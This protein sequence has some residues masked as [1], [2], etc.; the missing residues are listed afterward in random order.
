VP[1]SALR[2]L[3]RMR[4]VLAGAT[5]VLAAGILLYAVSGRSPSRHRDGTYRS[6]LQELVAAAGQRRTFEPRVTGNFAYGTLVA[7][8]PT[9]SAASSPDD[10]PLVLRAAAI[11][12]EK[13]ARAS[14][15]PLALNAFGIA[16][17]V[18]GQTA[19]A[20]ATL[21][22]AIRLA[23]KDARLSSDLAAGYLVRGRESSR[24]ED[25]ARAVGLA[26]QATELD[27]RLA[28]ARF[29]LALSLE[30]L[31]LRS[32]ASRAWQSYLAV[33]STSEWAAEA[34]RHLEQLSETPE[35]RWEKQRREIIAA[36]DRGDEASIRAA[37]GRFPDTAYE[38][39]ENDLIPAWADAWLARDV[40][41]AA[42]SLKLA[43]L[44]GQALADGVGDRMALDA[45]V[46]IERA[47]VNQDRADRLARAHQLFRDGR[48]VYEQDRVAES[49]GRFAQARPALLDCRSPFAQ[50]TALQEGIGR[51]YRG[52][53]EQANRLLDALIDDPSTKT[54]IR[55]RGRA[56][57]M[58]GLIQMVTGHVANSL[59]SYKEALGLFDSAGAIGDQA[60]MHSSIAEALEAIG[61]LGTAWAHKREALARLDV[62]RMPRRRETI[63]ASSA[64]MARRGN[65]LEAAVAFQ[66]ELVSDAQLAARAGAV[67]EG[68][69][70]R[71]EVWY[72]LDR[73]DV[74]LRD[75][76]EAKR[77]TARIPDEALAKRTRAEI[78]LASGQTRQAANSQRSIETLRASLAYFRELRMEQREP[79]V[80]LALG[81]AQVLAGQR[82]AAEVSFL[83]GIQ[84]LE[85]QRARLPGGQ[86]RLAY[87]DQ[88]WN[89]FDE[90]IRL[91][92]AIPAKLPAAL[93][94]AERFRARALAEAAG[95][96]DRAPLVNPASLADRLRP[97][98]A[99][100]FYVCLEDRL[101]TWV[102]RSHRVDFN[103][104]KLPSRDLEVEVR[105][106]R[107]S[108]A[109]GESD[110]VDRGGAR[111][112]DRLIRPLL[113]WLEGVTTLTVMPDGELHGVP[114]AGLKN[115]LT[116]HYL[117]ED[118]AINVAPS[119]TTFDTA[120]SRLRRIR[121]AQGASLLVLANPRLDAADAGALPDLS[122]AEAEARDLAALY[123][124]A[125]VL[126]GSRA[127]KRAFLGTAP[128]SRIV[129][130]AGHAVSNE[131]YSLLSRLLLAR[132]GPHEAGSLFAHEIMQLK[133]D[134]TDL[135]VLAACR[136]GAGQV[137]KGEGVISLARPFLAVGVPSVIATLW[138]VNDA[139]S[140]ALFAYFYE[141]LR[142]GAEPAVALR[143]AQLRLLRDDDLSLRSPA[144]WA[145]F[146][147]LGG[148]QSNGGQ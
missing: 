114:F 130:F 80:N 30:R 98:S 16:Q 124:G 90:M 7:A 142:Q 116:G 69:L 45:A 42:N 54:H 106:Y 12:L 139:A 82:H 137:K 19:G 125:T 70:G 50:W 103:E 133:L 148:S 112:Y 39:V 97:D 23:P 17:L 145:P 68:Y 10:S 136:T 113:P 21:E 66:T 59:D 43:R 53:F 36:G 52:D 35:M 85:A 144:A 134:A 72:L 8:A 126:T 140:R 105:S 75:L 109:S 129:H 11:A 5:V 117:I 138:D 41:K 71:A 73:E 2:G 57:W 37:T 64:K 55:L 95:G 132:D 146:I 56:R 25:V 38:Y 102:I 74:A 88:P 83:E 84:A 121:L 63:L 44:Y 104:Q 120:S 47:S 28:E 14:A 87:F 123:P 79:R 128:R 76:E 6:D 61:D 115:K 67:A 81:R 32:E 48:A 18:T 29:N 22:E 49:L 27:P 94:F 33:D 62:L 100:V 4:S 110:G 147:S 20:V 15:E 51:Y 86:L 135:V 91:Q 65:M 131:Q 34:R 141:S 143:D 107:A 96:R 77:W 108:L 46:A 26:E 127:T 99:V 3:L 118:H 78:M 9:R 31:S 101:L 60:A 111:L 24:I 40:A 93:M 1:Q 122:Q 89:L 119:A 13:R 58:K 92:S